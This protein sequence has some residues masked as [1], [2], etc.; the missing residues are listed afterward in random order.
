MRRVENRLSGPFRK[1][2]GDLFD[3]ML[4]P[5]MERSPECF[6]DRDLRFACIVV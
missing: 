3:Q 1:R 5:G 4:F 6:A 2:P